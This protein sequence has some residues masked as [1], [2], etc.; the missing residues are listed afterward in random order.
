MS[1]CTSDWEFLGLSGTES[2]RKRLGGLYW[3]A[4]NSLPWILHERIW[5]KFYGEP[6]RGCQ[7]ALQENIR[8][9]SD[10]GVYDLF[11]YFFIEK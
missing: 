6:L 7:K 5:Y 8:S 4:V 1:L 11:R 3:A 10:N 2:L 9:I